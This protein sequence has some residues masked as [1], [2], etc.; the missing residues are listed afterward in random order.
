MVK[1]TVRLSRPPFKV[2]DLVLSTKDILF[3]SAFGPAS[4]VMG[5]ELGRIVKIVKNARIQDVNPFC[6]DDEYEKKIGGHS[7]VL[8]VLWLTGEHVDCCTATHKSTVVK[9]LDA[10]ELEAGFTSEPEL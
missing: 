8:D 3:P 10:D 7:T 9:I 6:D 4:R 2:G 5:G 1:K